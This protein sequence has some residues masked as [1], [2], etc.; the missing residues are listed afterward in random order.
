[1]VKRIVDMPDTEP[2]DKNFPLPSEGDHLFQVTDIL[3]LD[4]NQDIVHVKCEVADKEELGRT[5]LHRLSLD[6]SFKGF[7][8]TR[9]FLKAIHKEYKGSNID[10]DTDDWIG[11]EFYA[12]VVHNGQYANITYFLDKETPKKETW[13]E[14]EKEPNL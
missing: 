11:E 10:I 4:P 13:N 12:N 14:E 6:V 9:I 1:M 3:Q 7:F 2:S 8:A 5:L